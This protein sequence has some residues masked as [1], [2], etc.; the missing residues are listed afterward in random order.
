MAMLPWRKKL[1]AISDCRRP[2]AKIVKEE[3][4]DVFCTELHVNHS[5]CDV[6]YTKTL[7]LFGEQGVI[8]LTELCG[9][10]AMLAMVMNVAQTPVL[11]GGDGL[12][13]LVRYS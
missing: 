10:Y 6:S 4:V 1:S 11:A 9:Y 2:S 7:A 5:L 8:D 12:K 13:A 3:I